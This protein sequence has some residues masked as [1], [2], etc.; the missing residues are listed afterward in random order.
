MSQQDKTGLHGD[1]SGSVT[2]IIMSD[3]ETGSE[4]QGQDPLTEC[5]MQRPNKRT[6]QQVKYMEIKLLNKLICEDLKEIWLSVDF[7]FKCSK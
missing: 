2:G 3:G 1:P 4:L 7:V 6:P 5:H